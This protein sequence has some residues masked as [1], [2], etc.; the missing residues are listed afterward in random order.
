MTKS[1]RLNKA[2]TNAGRI[3]LRESGSQAH[4]DDVV[5]IATS[6]LK[7]VE[8]ERVESASDEAARNKYNSHSTTTKRQ[9]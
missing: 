3:E 5:C 2:D 4:D 6:R 9:T 8:E 7:A 1:F